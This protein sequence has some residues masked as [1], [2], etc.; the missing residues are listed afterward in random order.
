MKIK[1]VD[2][3]FDEAIKYAN[4]D[5]LLLKHY[6]HGILLNDYQVN[7]TINKTYQCDVHLDIILLKEEN[8]TI[9]AFLPKILTRI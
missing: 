8:I 6:D 9:V 3:N 1:N 4:H 2:I 7:I 5:E